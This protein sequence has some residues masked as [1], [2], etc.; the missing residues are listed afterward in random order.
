MIREFRKL[1]EKEYKTKN[2]QVRKVIHWELSKRLKLDH[3]S[4]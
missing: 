1:A 4:K 2:G 3:T